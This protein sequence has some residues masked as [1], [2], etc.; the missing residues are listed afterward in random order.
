MKFLTD[1]QAAFI[2]F[3]ENQAGPTGRANLAELRRVAT[4]P[5]SD[6]RDIRILGQY[7]PTTDGWSFEAHR[8][9]ATLFALYA[10]KFWDRTGRLKLPRFD[11]NEKR[12]SLGSS[13]RKLRHRLKVGQDSLDLRFSAL[14]DTSHE[15]LAVPLRGIIQRI[16]TA[17]K[18][19]PVDFRR[20][21]TDIIYWNTDET[22]RIWARDYWQ[23]ISTEGEETMTES[24]DHI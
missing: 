22:Q 11:A 24:S 20:L 1:E 14:L 19:I 2:G 17:D 12:R 3:L 13:L 23:S 16:A 5:L 8:L 10:T 9:T 18:P 6:Y 7:L 15:D 21:L 4:N